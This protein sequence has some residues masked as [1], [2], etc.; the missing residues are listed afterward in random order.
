MTNS[1]TLNKSHKDRIPIWIALSDFYLDTE[2]QD[3]DFSH[4]ASIIKKSPYSLAEIKQINREDV[5]PILYSNLLYE[6][7]NWSGFQEE[8]LVGKIQKRIQNRTSIRRIS[9]SIKYWCF[10]GMNKEYW[11]K[12]EEKIKEV[13]NGL[14]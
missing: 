14:D 7:G 10:R 2:L 6:A 12:L 1:V 5:F 11:T 9:D 3:H 13:E 8:W 4:I